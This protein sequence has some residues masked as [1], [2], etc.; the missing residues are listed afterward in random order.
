MTEGRKSLRRASWSPLPPPRTLEEAKERLRADRGVLAP[1]DHARRLPGPPLA[2]L[3]PAQRADA[4]GPDVRA[5]RSAARG[6]HHLAAGDPGRRAQLGLSLRLGARLDLRPVGP[7]HAGLRPR[8]RRLLL[9]H[10]RRLPRRDDLQVM[11]G[12]GGERELDEEIAAAPPRLRGRVPG[13]DRQRR[14]LT[15]SST[16]SGA[17]CWTPS[18]C[19][20]RSR[21]GLLGVAVARPQAAG[22]G[23]RGALGAA[24]PRG[25][26][27]CAANP[28]TSR[29]A[30]SC[31]GLRWTV[32]P[33]ARMHEERVR[34]A[35][36][37]RSPTR[38]RR[39]SATNGVDERGVFTQHYGATPSM[40]RCC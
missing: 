23:G 31:A 21:D 19:T 26:G 20:S 8:G 34:R 22:R 12:V 11:Y 36:G 16:T 9:L 4:Q 35:S 14:V 13:S 17:P 25:S 32:A 27:R 10:R 30:S 1:M 33:A 7:V 29:P 28:S 37:R 6:G 2:Q 38:S 39:T 24:G 40:R 5:H 15:S 18:T 3:P